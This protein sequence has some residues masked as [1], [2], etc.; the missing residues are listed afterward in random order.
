MAEPGVLRDRIDVADVGRARF[1]DCRRI[2]LFSLP[3]AT[4]TL[5]E[6]LTL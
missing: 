1:F 6:K 4:G 2:D 5:T 3:S